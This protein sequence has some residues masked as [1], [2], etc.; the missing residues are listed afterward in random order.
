MQNDFEIN[1]IDYK[2][3]DPPVQVCNATHDR[4]H[5]DKVLEDYVTLVVVNV[6]ATFFNSPFADQSTTVQ[7]RQ[8]VFVKLLQSAFRL[9]H[10][11]WLSGQQRYSVESCIRTLSDIG[12]HA[13]NWSLIT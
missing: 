7:S 4:R 9:S 8:P 13:F 10:C 2:T 5:A 12:E 1:S 11:T 3:D 6:I